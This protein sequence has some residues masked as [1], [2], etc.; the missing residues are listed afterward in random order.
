MLLPPDDAQICFIQIVLFIEMYLFTIFS[1]ASGIR[2]GPP[3]PVMGKSMFGG[4]MEPYKRGPPQDYLDALEK[5]NQK[6][7][8]DVN[9]YFCSQKP[10]FFLPE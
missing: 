10:F 6:D 7:L 2:G 5:A 3:P 8:E 4:P 1:G 9:M